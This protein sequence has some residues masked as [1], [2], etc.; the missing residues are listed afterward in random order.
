MSFRI[1]TMIGVLFIELVLVSM[2]IGSNV[3]NLTHQI[4]GDLKKRAE[5]IGN[6]FASTAKNAITSFDIATMDDYVNDIAKNEDIVYARIVKGEVILSEAG[7][8]VS[9]DKSFDKHLKLEAIDDEVFDVQ[10][11]VIEAGKAFANVQLGIS[12]SKLQKSIDE[13]KNKAIFI[14]VIGLT[15]SALF[16]FL[17]GTFLTQKL[18]TLRRASKSISEENYDIELPDSGSDEIAATSRAFNLMSRRI[19][20]KI[21][22]LNE[23]KD[24]ADKAS[25]AK[26]L[27]LANMSHELRTPLNAIINFSKHLERGTQGSDTESIIRKIS[28]SSQN[29]MSMLN[30]VLDISKIEADEFSL[31]FIDFSLEDMIKNTAEI[32]E[33]QCKGNGLE[34]ECEYD[35]IKGHT[36]FSDPT[37]IQ[38]IVTNLLSNSVKFTEKGLIKLSVS[39]E[40]DEANSQSSILIEIKDSGIGIPENA[41]ENLFDVFVQADESTSRRYGGTGLGLAICKKIVSKLKGEISLDSVQGIGTRF[42]VKIPVEKKINQRIDDFQAVPCNS[43]S[44]NRILVCEDNELNVEVLEMIFKEIDQEADFAVNGKS[45]Y[46]LFKASKYDLILMDFQMPV[47]D[48]FEATKLIRSYESQHDLQRTPVIAM[49]AN[50]IAKHKSKAKEIGMDE[51]LTKPFDIS[52][53]VHIINTYGKTAQRIPVVGDISSE[54]LIADNSSDDTE[55]SDENFVDADAIERLKYLDSAEEPD[56]AEKKIKSFV[57]SNKDIIEE[58]KEAYLDRDYQMIKSIAHKFKTSCGIVG[59]KKLS[60]LCEIL[61]EASV[62]RNDLEILN[63]IDQWIRVAHSTKQALLQNIASEE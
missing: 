10:F 23:E 19:K 9:S 31:D 57:S 56:F 55:F 47:M 51:Y 60:Y 35:E 42:V 43:T 28:L 30:D 17:L 50:A 38:Q 34:F 49:T 37:R 29:L 40:I 15:L 27:F 18:A 54:N 4:E 39:N 24:R 22:L 1:R 33:E 59:A 16:S 45:G 48:G 21:V 63:A 11:P 61:E 52:Q 20:D 3:L 53:L 14:G 32:F 46:E 2:L 44:T 8:K 13:E 5:F 62:N 6:V 41:Q 12:T 25:E 7:V 58:V 26:S 36:Y